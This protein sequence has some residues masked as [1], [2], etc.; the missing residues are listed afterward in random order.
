MC[1]EILVR[2]RLLTTAD[3]DRALLQIKADGTYAKISRQ[4]FGQDV[5]KP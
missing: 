1:G 2:R 5:S 4:W 3:V